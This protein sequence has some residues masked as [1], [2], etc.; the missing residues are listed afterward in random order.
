[1]KYDV[2][3]I[4]GGPAGLSAGI[5]AS[6]AGL[7]TLC[8]EKLCCGGQA[9]ISPEIAN[10]PGL[11]LISGFDLGQKMAEDAT[12]A[13][14]EFEYATV[15][16]LTQTKTGFCVKTKSNTFSCKKVILACGAKTRQLSLPNEQN[17]IGKGVSYCASCDGAFFKGKNVAVVGGGNTAITDVVYLARLAKKVYLIHRRNEFRANANEVN[18]VKALKN[19]EII[20]PATIEQ[21]NG[22]NQLES[23]VLN[24][25][26]K[27]KKLK[28]AGLFV[29][30]GYEPDLSFV[31]IN[32]KKDKN[33][34]VLVDE[35]M[36]TSVKYLYACGDIVSKSF[37]QIVTAAADGAIA[38]NS[39][40]G[41]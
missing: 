24:L 23:L 21:L 38:G 32:I 5:F 10:Y 25:D 18:K 9:C 31:D 37:K 26:G 1:M 27:T 17:L 8:I 11:G 14:V 22:E 16:K 28:V 33:G 41:D 2:V 35:N 20:T 6:R 19:V 13:G 3:I 4:G 36:Q 15:Q 12:K 39:C 34:Y 30:I 40:I 7:K 29:A